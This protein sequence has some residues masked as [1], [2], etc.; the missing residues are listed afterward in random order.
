M[1]LAGIPSPH[2]IDA[3]LDADAW[4]Q[5]I[6]EERFYFFAQ[7]G[8][9]HAVTNLCCTFG[10]A[11][12]SSPRAR[13]NVFAIALTA[14]SAAVYAVDTDLMATASSSNTLPQTSSTIDRNDSTMVGVGS[15]L[16]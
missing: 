3:H 9:R 16:S 14:I 2:K 6:A 13:C 11:N 12:V 8:N 1:L 4:P 15:R 7:H 5:N 10:A